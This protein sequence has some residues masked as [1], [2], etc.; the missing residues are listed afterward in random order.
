[1]K[2]KVTE[3]ALLAR[4][5]RLLR[6]DNQQLCR[7]REGSRAYAELGDFYALDTARDVVMARHVDLAMWARDMGILPDWEELQR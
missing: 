5:N 1:M 3:R 6:Q 7:C 4:I 2:V